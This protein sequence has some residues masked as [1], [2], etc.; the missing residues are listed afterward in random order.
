MVFKNICGLWSATA[1]TCLA[2]N[3]DCWLSKIIPRMSRTRAA[4]LIGHAASRATRSRAYWLGPGRGP[5]SLIP[6]L[7]GATDLSP[8]VGY[9]ISLLAPFARRRPYSDAVVVNLGG[10]PLRQSPRS[11]PKEPDNCKPNRS[12]RSITSV[13]QFPAL[14]CPFRECRIYLAL[15]RHVTPATNP[16]G[17]VVPLLAH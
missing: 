15:G 7:E 5:P 11:P 9:L 16:H 1:A 12:R 2:G 10:Q 3:R 6:R 17:S 8:G 14:R 4:A 13:H